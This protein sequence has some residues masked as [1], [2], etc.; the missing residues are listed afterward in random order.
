M[1]MDLG[2]LWELVID[3]E[4]WGAAVHGVT[5]SRTRL[6]N[7][8]ELNNGKFKK[9]FFFNISVWLVGS[10]FPDKGLNQGHD[11]ENLEY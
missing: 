11:S 3:R 1:D 10:Q 4:D 2:G 5:K 9:K 8:T 7:W 6:G